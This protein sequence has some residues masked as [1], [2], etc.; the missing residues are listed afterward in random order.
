[1]ETALVIGTGGFI[2]NYLGK[3]LKKEGYLVRGVDIKHTEFGKTETEDFGI[4]TDTQG[5]NEVYA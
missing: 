3:G 1:M 4:K 2:A 5:F